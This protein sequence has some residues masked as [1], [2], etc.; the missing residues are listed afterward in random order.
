MHHHFHQGNKSE[1]I[2]HLKRIAE[3]TEPENPME[4]ACYYRGLVMLG[5]Y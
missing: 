5:R 3:L 1:G 4:K 2:E